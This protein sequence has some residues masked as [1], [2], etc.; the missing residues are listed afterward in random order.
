MLS[1]SG[2]TSAYAHFTTTGFIPFDGG[3]NH[4]YR[5]GGEGITWNE[6]G[7]RIAW[8]NADF[9]LKSSV[10]KYDKIGASIYYPTK[11]DDPNAAVAFST[12][13]NVAP[14]QGAAYFRVSAKGKGE[15]LV[16]TLDEKIE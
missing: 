3:A 10:V 2:A 11:I 9:T 6:Y 15:N 5:I 1:S 8:Y 14:P 7:A 12:D 16:V 13:A 4:I